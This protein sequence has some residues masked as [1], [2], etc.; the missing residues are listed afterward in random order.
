MAV[1]REQSAVKRLTDS[2]ADMRWDHK[3]FGRLAAEQPAPMTV[4][5]A[6]SFLSFFEMLS[7]RYEAGDFENEEMRKVCRL[8]K[9]I[10]QAWYDEYFIDN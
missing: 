10:T 8:S 7:L 5:L 3:M 4:E 9:R 2:V 6:G 1:G